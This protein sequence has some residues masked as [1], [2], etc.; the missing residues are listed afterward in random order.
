M[1]KRPPMEWTSF[2]EE[3]IVVTYE[4]IYAMSKGKDVAEL[5][6][7]DLAFV[8]RLKARNRPQAMVNKAEKAVVR[9]ALIAKYHKAMEWAAK[10]CLS[11]AE[12]LIKLVNDNFLDKK[13][14][15]GIETQIHLLKHTLTLDF[16]EKY[17]ART[18]TEIK[19]LMSILAKMDD[20]WKTTEAKK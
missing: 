10:S 15:G 14:R 8:E 3:S 19:K 6:E 18:K 11:E 7:E 20:Y 13:Y 12:D 2:A 1:I 16:L 5:N 17:H 9:E 4:E